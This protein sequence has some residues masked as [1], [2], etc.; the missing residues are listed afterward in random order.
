[1][2]KKASLII[3]VIL[4]FFLFTYL[5]KSQR[6]VDLFESFSLS[7]HLPFT[8]FHEPEKPDTIIRNIPLDGVLIDEDFEDGLVAG[9]WDSL[10]ARETGTVIRRLDRDAEKGTNYIFIK[11]LGHEDWT[12]EHDRLIMVSPGEQFHYQGRIK[13][14]GQASAGLGVALYDKDRQIVDWMHAAGM[15]QYQEEWTEISNSFAIPENVSFMRFRLAGSGRGEV[16]ADDFLLKRTKSIDNRDRQSPGIDF[17][18]WQPNP[19]TE[20]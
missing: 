11:N 9:G 7:K 1:M 14:T 5:L 2:I 3:I 6:G 19:G 18:P 16:F 13:T 10:W 12:I 17:S 20:R 8:S 4:L 15:V